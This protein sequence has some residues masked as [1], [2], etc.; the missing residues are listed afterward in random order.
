MSDIPYLYS[1]TGH[2]AALPAKYTTCDLLS[3]RDE[4]AQLILCS[5]IKSPFKHYV[6]LSCVT[7]VTSSVG[8]E[9][10]SLTC[11]VKLGA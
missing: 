9:V 10:A 11:T 8:T 7:R 5:Y 1:M 2:V 4:L 6:D 3:D